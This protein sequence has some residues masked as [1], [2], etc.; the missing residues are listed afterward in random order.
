MARPT[1]M[2]GLVDAL[3]R[4]PIF[5]VPTDIVLPLPEPIRLRVWATVGGAKQRT[6]SN[7][8]ADPIDISGY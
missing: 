7:T 8:G 1:G 3:K 5:G 4:C 2:H 6:G